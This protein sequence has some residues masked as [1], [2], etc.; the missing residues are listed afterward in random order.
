[1]DAQLPP[2]LARFIKEQ[3]Y[4][5]ETVREVGLR[6]AEDSAI[7]DYARAG[8]L[9]LLTKDEDF[10]ER[11][12]RTEDGPQIIWLRIGNCTN[13]ALNAWLA[14]LWPTILQQL[15]SGN[16]LIEVRR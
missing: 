12:F 10:A 13:S 16:R 3:G 6:E 2:G 8:G 7:W 14:P 5:A 15:E 9:I 1:M 4:D 11:T